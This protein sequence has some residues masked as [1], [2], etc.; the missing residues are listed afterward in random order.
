ME[1]NSDG[2]SESSGGVSSTD[3]PVN[4]MSKLRVSVSL[5]T[6]GTNGGVI[7]KTKQTRM[8][9]FEKGVQRWATLK[10]NLCMDR[11][12]FVTC[13]NPNRYP[14]A[15]MELY[16]KGSELRKSERQK[17]KI[18]FENLIMIRTSKAL[19]GSAHW[20][21]RTTTTTYGIVPMDTKAC[22]GLG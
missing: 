9:Y 7:W 10:W 13:D 17:S 4:S 18:T 8:T 16:G 5:I 20:Q 15:I 14:F 3:S 19:K 1:V 12:L 11:M 22:G 21:I 2:W 6:W